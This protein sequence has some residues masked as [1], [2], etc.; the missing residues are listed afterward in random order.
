M[1]RTW[2]RWVRS[3]LFRTVVSVG[4]VRDRFSGQVIATGSGV[5]IWMTNI[6][7]RSEYLTQILL[8]AP[9]WVDVSVILDSLGWEREHLDEVVA[10][11]SG[12][13]E[14]DSLLRRLRVRQT[15]SYSPG[16]PP[17]VLYHGT[18]KVAV[19][20]ILA[21]GLKKMGQ[22]HVYLASTI[23]MA[24]IEGGRRGESNMMAK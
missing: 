17:D 4:S 8:H 6:V 1:L 5:E 11:E 20:S 21:E 14:Y 7:Q 13:V 19:P 22:A 15:E 18:L 16:C 24:Q 9:G 12:R 10:A 2:C 23:E 3:S